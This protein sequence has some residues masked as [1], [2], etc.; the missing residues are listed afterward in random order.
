VESVGV[1][2]VYQGAGL[3]DGKK[4]L[5]FNLV[6]RA[7]DR[8]LTDVEVNGVFAAIQ[9]AVVADGTIAVRG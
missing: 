3:P 9:L 6:F 5:A 8:T 4:S 7:A 1:F 2:D